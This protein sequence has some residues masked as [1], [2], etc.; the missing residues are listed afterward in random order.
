MR[1]PSVTP[2]YLVAGY[3]GQ[4]HHVSLKMTGADTLPTN[5]FRPQSDGADRLDWRATRRKK[6]ALY[7]G[8]Q[9]RLIEK[10]RQ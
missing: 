10:H 1:N 3:R 7:Q 2:G 4:A 6:L 8:A 9:A 5:G